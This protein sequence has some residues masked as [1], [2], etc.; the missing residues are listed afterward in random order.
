MS[1]SLLAPSGILH[2][3]YLKRTFDEFGQVRNLI[4][5]FVVWKLAE[6]IE[7]GVFRDWSHLMAAYHYPS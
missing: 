6:A 2:N 4:L 5:N 1:E 3:F 7:A